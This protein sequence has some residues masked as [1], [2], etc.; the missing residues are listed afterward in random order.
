LFRKD[1]HFIKTSDLKEEFCDTKAWK[2]DWPNVVKLLESSAMK[3]LVHTA[4]TFN[5]FGELMHVPD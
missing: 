1:T 4:K 5:S 3:E 2:E